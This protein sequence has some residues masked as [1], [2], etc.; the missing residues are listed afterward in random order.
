MEQVFSFYFERE[1]NPG[2]VEGL[3]AAAAA[4]GVDGAAA[5]TFLQSSEGEAAVMREA[6]TLQRRY[7]ITGVPYFIIGDSIGISGAQ[8]PGTF[9]EALEEAAKEVGADAPAAA[10]TGTA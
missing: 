4:A 3:V 1:G 10:A 2:D 9:V 7:G 6:A 8:D 5:R